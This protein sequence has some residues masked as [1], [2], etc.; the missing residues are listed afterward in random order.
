MSPHLA[1]E[2]WDLDSVCRFRSNAS[3]KKCEISTIVKGLECNRS[4]SCTRPLG[5]RFGYCR[6]RR[7]AEFLL[8]HRYPQRFHLAIQMAAFQAKDFRGAAHVAVIFV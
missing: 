1:G 4:E 6:G 2:N 3:P 5:K 8:F 7:F